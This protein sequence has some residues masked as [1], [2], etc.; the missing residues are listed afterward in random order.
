MSVIK[1]FEKFIW[2]NRSYLNTHIHTS[3]KFC[4]AWKQFGA[5]QGLKLQV[6]QF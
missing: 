1:I 2:S 5:M 4:G 3:N 6:F